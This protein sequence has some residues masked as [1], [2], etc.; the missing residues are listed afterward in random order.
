[1]GNNETVRGKMGQWDLAGI[2][3][4]IE[5]RESDLQSW[6][7]LPDQQY[8]NRIINHKSDDK[9]EAGNGQCA[10]GGYRNDPGQ[11]LNGNKEYQH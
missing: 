6:P 8:L 7:K 2:R 1:M 9:G 3:E 11:S 4:S 10:H 5:P